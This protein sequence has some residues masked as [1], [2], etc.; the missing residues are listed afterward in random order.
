MARHEGTDGSEVVAP[1]TYQSSEFWEPVEVDG[2]GKAPDHDDVLADAARL[3][4]SM[5][6]RFV[7]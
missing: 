2:A 4:L 1:V 5:V 7:C 6:T 3:S